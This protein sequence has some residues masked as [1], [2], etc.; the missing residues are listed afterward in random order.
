MNED[1]EL[2]RTI[3]EQCWAEPAGAERMRGLVTDDYIHHSPMGDWSFDQFAAGLEWIDSRIG[4]RSYRMEHLILGDNG[5]AA[6][7]LSWTGVRR[8]GNEPVEGRGAYHCRIRDGQIAEDWD[9]FFP[10]S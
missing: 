6:A 7:Y 10:A 4:E 3:V 5:M 2:V 9:V 8:E 1:A